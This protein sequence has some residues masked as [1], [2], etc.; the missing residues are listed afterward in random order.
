METQLQPFETQNT[1]KASIAYQ[2]SQQFN[3]LG[4]FKLSI[5]NETQIPSRISTNNSNT[6]H[7]LRAQLTNR[8]KLLFAQNHFEIQSVSTSINIIQ[9][10][11]KMKQQVSAMKEKTTSIRYTRTSP[12]V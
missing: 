2:N 1:G 10:S 8:E 7:I 9:N 5:T 3:N 11:S 4:H 12:R 6:S